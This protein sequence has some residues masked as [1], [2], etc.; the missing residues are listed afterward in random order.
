MSAVSIP[1]TEF[2]ATLLPAGRD[3][4]SVVLR[5]RG[6]GCVEQPGRPTPTLLPVGLLCPTTAGRHDWVLRAPSK[7]PTADE[8]ADDV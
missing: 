8:L 7:P 6:P 3:L 1:S 4:A 2:P 5:A